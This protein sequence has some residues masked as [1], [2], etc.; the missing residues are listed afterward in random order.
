MHLSLLSLSV[1][2][3]YV[4]ASPTGNFAIHEKRDANPVGWS[5]V[6]SLDRRALIPMKIALTQRNLDQGAEHLNSVSHPS[7]AKYGKHW[8]AQEVADYFA[9]RYVKPVYLKT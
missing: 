5:K 9:P 6:E 1:L 8:T 3:S 7:S 4:L 2:V